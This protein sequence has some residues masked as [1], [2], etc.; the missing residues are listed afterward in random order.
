MCV[1]AVAFASKPPGWDGLAK[2][3]EV[4]QA[5]D[6]GKC[7]YVASVTHAW[8]RDG[9]KGGMDVSEAL[10]KG[11][12][13]YDMSKLCTDEQ[14]EVLS[15]G[16]GVYDPSKA[17]VFDHYFTVLK[18]GAKGEHALLLQGFCGDASAPEKSYTG[19][20]FYE[21]INVHFGGTAEKA[22]VPNLAHDMPMKCTE[23]RDKLK[24][25]SDATKKSAIASAYN[26]LFAPP[27][28]QMGGKW[29]IWDDKDRGVYELGMKSGY[30]KFGSSFLLLSENRL[31]RKLKFARA[32]PRLQH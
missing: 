8:F 1:V 20:L 23:L 7:D 2:D 11:G 29:K 14:A 22:G 30:H 15:F 32:K 5:L 28:D 18:Y 19:R 10:H 17:R 12:A 31:K 9:K 13:I 24:A 4:W 27:N 6:S 26:Y 3:A 21:H 25:L 16:V